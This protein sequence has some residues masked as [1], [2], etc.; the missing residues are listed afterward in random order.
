MNPLLTVVIIS[1]NTEKYI[2]KCINSV[3]DSTYENLDII[4]IDNHSTD[5]TRKLI[6]RSFN[7]WDFNRIRWVYNSD[8]MGCPYAENQGLS[9]AKGKYISFICGD[10]KVNRHYFSEIVSLF[11][12]DPTIGAIGGKMLQ[13][14]M[15]KID[16]VGE[17]I[18]QY[19]LLEQRH[20][21]FENK[22]DSFTEQADIFSI[23][24]A[25]LS[26]RAKVLKEIGGFP[27]DYFM[28]LE[29]TDTCWRIWL[30]GYRVVY[31]PGALIFHAT[32]SSIDAHP[33]K[34]RLVKYLGTRN[35]IYTIFKNAG[36]KNLLLILPLNICMWIAICVYLLCKRRFTES[37]YVLMGIWW[38]FAHPLYA[39]K[40]RIKTQ[41]LRMVSDKRLFKN[42]T[43]RVSLWHLANKAM[44]W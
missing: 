34:D 5:D 35:Y 30:S 19:L 28:F 13:M 18:N 42:I 33:E 9:L 10:T 8:N 36:I 4:F 27:N 3:L 38:I 32:S 24:G 2:I 6:Y 40:S 12:S 29:E 37:K 26:C 22:I 21:G 25:G 15:P 16:S 7:S 11:E 39:L 1:W 20:K 31:C 43:K 17:Y 41:K 23:K 44:G 14:H